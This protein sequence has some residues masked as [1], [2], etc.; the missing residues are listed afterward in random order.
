MYIYIYIFIINYAIS[1]IHNYCKIHSKY[2]RLVSM[3]QSSGHVMIA[4]RV[5][6]DR[7]VRTTMQG[8]LLK[9]LVRSTEDL[10]PT[11]SVCLLV[12]VS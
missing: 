2:I 10:L 7:Q 4:Y 1:F 3:V 5:Q 8:H 12:V 11:L 6:A 9:D